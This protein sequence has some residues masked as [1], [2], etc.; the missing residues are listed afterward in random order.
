MRIL[1][2]GEYSRL[3]SSLKAGLQQ[4]GHQVTV[5]GTGDYFKKYPV[6]LSFEPKS[7]RYHPIF[8]FLKRLCYRIFKLNLEETETAIRFYFLVPKLKNYDVVQLINSN[9]LETHPFCSRYLLK[10]LFTQNKKIFLL[11][12]GDETPVVDYLLQRK[13]SYDILT[14]L[15]ENHQLKKKFLYTLKYTNTSHR[16]LFEYVKKAAHKIIVSDIDYKIPMESMQ[17]KVAFIPNPI[18]I[19]QQ[20]SIKTPL[21]GTIKIFLGINQLSKIK[22]GLG[23]FEKALAVIKEKYPEKTQIL[24]VE[25]LPY[26]EYIKKYETAHILL[27]QVYAYD[28]GYNALEA[29]AKG[30]VVFTGAEKEFLEHYNLQE[31]E[32]CINALPDVKAIV[33]K[34]SWLIENPKEIERIS[35]NARLFIEREHHYVKIAQKYVAVWN[36]S[37]R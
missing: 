12:C 33:K 3:H 30:K 23:F 21:F 26:K 11:V 2:L 17:Y 16:Q 29:M 9:A 22:K 20:K 27:D 5:A 24:I 13:M 19:E 8:R 31:D 34:L 18:I 7:T 14:P 10:K 15:F 1:L 25:N 28:Q 32:V 37:T 4:L 36:T 35:Q 6:D